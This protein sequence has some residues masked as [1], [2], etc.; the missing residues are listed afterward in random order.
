MSKA[1]TK[2]VRALL[3]TASEMFDETGCVPGID[4]EEVRAETMVPDAKEYISESIDNP[5]VLCDSETWDRPGFTLVLSWLAQKWLR[6][7]QPGTQPVS[8]NISLA[9]SRR[10]LTSLVVGLL[11]IGFSC[12]C[13]LPEGHPPPSSV[14]KSRRFTGQDLPCF[15]RIAH[16]GTVDCCIHPPG[17]YET[18]AVTPRRFFPKEVAQKQ[19]TLLPRQDLPHCQK[20]FQTKFS[21]MADLTEHQIC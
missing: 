2:E 8:S 7:C 12:R 4:G 21:G 6:K 13:L 20:S 10:A 5:Q 9:V 11:M 17:R 18:I 15:G 3:D 19:A 14:M 16:L 1:T